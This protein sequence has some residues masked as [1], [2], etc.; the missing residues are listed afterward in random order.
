[1][2]R[3][4]PSQRSDTKDWLPDCDHL[5]NDS[6][7]STYRRAM[8][9]AVGFGHMA[10]PAWRG[11][12]HAW[13][14]PVAAVTA[15]VFVAAAEGARERIGVGVWGTTMTALFAVS[16]IYHRGRWRPAVK[17]WWQRVDHA[18]IFVFIA[19]SYTPVSLLL[20]EGSSSWLVLTISW[21]GAIAGVVLRLTWHT[22]PRWLF[23]PLYLMLSW[24]AV[25]VLPNLAAA[26]PAAANW[27]LVVG[28]VLY[29]VGALV[30]ATKWPDPRPAVFGFHE[31]F[32]ALTIAAASCHAVAIGLAVAHGPVG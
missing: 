14:A 2:Q 19:G 3:Y 9:E 31:V 13:A 26:A 7:A 18:M 25:T 32:H 22:A 27:L 28:G 15:I 21:G 29:T 4:A 17:A 30:F 6:G 8:T 11:R 23:V 1:M 5:D 12:L 10:R 24:V 16:A 20:L